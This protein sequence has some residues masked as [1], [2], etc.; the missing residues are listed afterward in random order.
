MSSFFTSDFHNHTKFCNHASGEPEDYI[1]NAI[2]MNI[3]R[4][5]FLE[6]IEVGVNLP[7]RLWM[8]VEDIPEYIE[9][10]RYL[11][12]R[13]KGE[14]EILCGVELGFNPFAIKE[15]VE[16]VKKYKFDVVGLS[17]HHKYLPQVDRWINL[18]SVRNFDS[19]IF[20]FMDEKEIVIDYLNTLISAIDIFKPDFLCHLNAISK[21]VKFDLTDIEVIDSLKI[22]LQKVASKN[23]KLE[24]NLSG[25]DYVN[26]PFPSYEIINLAKIFGIKFIMG[27]DSH[28]PREVGK[29]I[30]KF[31]EYLEEK[32]LEIF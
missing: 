26:E 6:H 7:R 8:R 10:C 4:F 9:M 32:N 21:N 24:I 14:I 12:E 13:F 29:N 20:E 28:S 31:K 30:F 11:K 5:A 22:L 18:V 19:K 15:L 27:S 16:I 23:I 25:F 1:R 2:D 3:N 17:Y